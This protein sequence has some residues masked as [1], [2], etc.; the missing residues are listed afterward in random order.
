MS[1]GQARELLGLEP[2]AGGEAVDQA[3]RMA[4]KSSHPDRDGGDAERLRQVIE[5]H[6]LLKSMLAAPVAF[7]LVRKPA[8]PKPAAP[9]R[10]EI[11]V[12]E[13]LYG[14]AC[15]VEL[16]EGRRLNV[17]LPP[18]LRTGDVLRLARADDGDDLLLRIA[19]GNEAGLTV[20]GGDLWVETE[21]DAE[22]IQDGGCLEVVTPRGRRMFPA[23][24][25]TE[26]SGMVMVRF[27]G[28]G[29]PARGPHGAGDLVIALTVREARSRALLRRFSARWAA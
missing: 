12:L 29:L 26:D 1:A 23:P 15:E 10:L 25:V 4:V 2:G 6:R 13:A 16:D 9:R 18:G 27:K 21:I 3:Y 24:S 28:D 20:R 7:S 14:G 19:V 22:A 8:E 17:Q 11:S 5:A